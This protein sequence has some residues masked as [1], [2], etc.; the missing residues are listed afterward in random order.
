VAH[1]VKVRYIGLITNADASILGV[2]LEDG[3]KFVEP[4]V[5]D[6]LALLA[7]LEG[8]DAGRLL[9]LLPSA[10]FHRAGG[11]P[12]GVIWVEKET[13]LATPGNRPFLAPPSLKEFE[14]LNHTFRLMRLFKSGCIEV[15][16]EYW[17]VDSPGLPQ[18][19]GT[20]WSSGPFSF[21][22][23]HLEAS[24]VPQLIEFLNA[25]R[26]LPPHPYIEAALKLYD[27]SY[28]AYGRGIPM[29]IVSAGLETLLN[30][31]RVE[32]TYRVSRNLAALL[33]KDGAEFGSIQKEVKDLYDARSKFVHAGDE[34]GLETDEVNRF[35]H[36]LRE[37]IKR[38]WDL[39]LPKK[40]LCERLNV[41]G[42]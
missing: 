26:S 34:R 3:F 41:R 12:T 7:R 2:P 6:A 32:V 8:V 23:H 29:V 17:F 27:E 20:R 42:F 4:P 28:R 19:V 11:G 22:P 24:E 5:S 39:R 13:N 18:G 37:A 38:A 1:D 36:F 10:I 14:T 35:R 30:P 9:R 15:P 25:H 33:A 31:S 21:E 40:T 16:R